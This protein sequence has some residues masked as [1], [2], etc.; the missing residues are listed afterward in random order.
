MV[1]RSKAPIA[2]SDAADS[3]SSLAN[4][5]SAANASSPLSRMT[6][7]IFADARETSLL[8][9]T[10][11]LCG[12]A[13]CC[14]SNGPGS[15]PGPFPD[16]FRS[17]GAETGRPPWVRFPGRDLVPKSAA[18]DARRSM[19]TGFVPFFEIGLLVRRSL[20]LLGVTLPG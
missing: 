15:E 4:L 16:G 20:L 13:N 8:F 3:F 14:Q 12:V 19:R 18:R 6:T 9:I 10:L 11:L 1:A 17:K 2:V 7:R 5:V